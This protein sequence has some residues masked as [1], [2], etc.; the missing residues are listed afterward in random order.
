MSDTEPIPWSESQQPDSPLLY[1]P[2]LTP[3]TR[4][5]PSESRTNRASSS[6]ERY[7]YQEALDR[8]AESL[9]TA[10]QLISNL[11]EYEDPSEDVEEAKE[12]VGSS[13]QRLIETATE[14]ELLTDPPSGGRRIYKST[15]RNSKS[16]TRGAGSSDTGEA[17]EG[18]GQKD[19]AGEDEEVAEQAGKK[20]GD[21]RARVNRVLHAYDA[22][23]DYSHICS[24]KGR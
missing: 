16:R 13:L 3:Q 6:P 12:Q 7:T 2:I 14:R 15:S 21:K 5:P 9:R 4:T 1:S 20:R 23:A 24:I 8:I 10:E 22:E 11:H 18:E 17:A 19:T